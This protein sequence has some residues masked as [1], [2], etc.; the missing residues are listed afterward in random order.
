MIELE[1][2][3]GR[4]AMG[5]GPRISTPATKTCRR[6]PRIS[7]PATKTCRRGP[8]ISTPQTKTYLRGPRVYEQLSEVFSDLYASCVERYRRKRGDHRDAAG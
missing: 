2:S 4:N 3:R 5:I 6:G 1:L 7:T 8:R